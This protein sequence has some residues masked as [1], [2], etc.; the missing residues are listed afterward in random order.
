M[1]LSFGSLNA[2]LIFEMA[3]PPEPGETLLSRRFRME[4]GGKGANQAVAA[5][6][7]GA[8][9]AMIG[10]VGRDGLAD[11]VLRHLRDAGVDTTRVDAVDEATG[12]ASIIVDDA[13]RNQIVVAAG[14]NGSA[15]AD[16]IDD[17]LLRPGTHVLL[18]MEVPATEVATAIR[19]ARSR[20]A[21]AILNLAPA[22]EIEPAALSACGLLVV[23]EQEAATVAGRLGCSAD[24][25]TLAA[26]LGTGVLRTLGGDGAEAMTAEGHCR[27]PALDITPVDTTAAGDCLIGVLAAGLAEGRGFEAALRRATVAAALCCGRRGSQ[28]SLP[29][30]DEIDRGGG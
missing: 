11:L 27:V 26:V 28:S 7:A 20:G 17:D 30:R 29:W 5:A 8:E 4:P 16:R 12:C 19:R 10:A 23:N 21:V 13:G 18:Q 15:A 22:G 9:V 1:I 14:A 24:A 3:R 2:D 6:R 25:T